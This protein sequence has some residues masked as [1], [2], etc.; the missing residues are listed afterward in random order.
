[1]VELEL[2]GDS[3][4]DMDDSDGD[5]L[6]AM[7]AAVK[8]TTP[9]SKVPEK[10]ETLDTSAAA[11]VIE[12]AAQ[13]ALEA[14]DAAEAAAAEA[15]SEDDLSEEEAH[16]MTRKERLRQ[17]K[18]AKAFFKADAKAAAVRRTG[19]VLEDEAEMSDDGGHTDDE[20][21]VEVEEE[22]ADREG[23]GVHAR[24]IKR[25]VAKRKDGLLDREELEE[26]V[27]Y[28]DF[29][30]TGDDDE[31]RTAKRAAAHAR[32]EE[33]RDDDELRK[34]QEALKNGF[35]RP[36]K[37]K[38]GI[39]GED[40]PDYW[41]RRRKVNGDD[42]DS[43]EEDDVGIDIPDRAWEAVELSDDDDGEWAERAERR[44]NA[45]AA[46][47]QA[48]KK[49]APAHD[50]T[51][52]APHDDWNNGGGAS[53][54]AGTSEGAGAGEDSQL[55]S[56]RD[57][58]FGSGSQ[59]FKAMMHAGRQRRNRVPRS[60]TAAAETGSGP[61]GG[62]GSFGAFAP[63]APQAAATR[64]SGTGGPGAGAEAGTRVGH[65]AQRPG[66]GAMGLE[67]Q[68]ST[69][70]SFMGRS[71]ASR[72]NHGGSSAGGGGGSSLGR[73]I[74]L[75]NGGASRS[76]VFGGGGDSQSMW[77]R[78]AEENGTAAAPTVLAELGGDDNA[79]TDFGWAPREAGG[80]KGQAAGA[81]LGVGAGVGAPMRF[82]GGGGS[83]GQSLFSMLQTSSQDWD[84]ALGR[85][86]SLAEGV[87][88][89]NNIKLPPGVPR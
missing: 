62:V 74:S 55:P 10:E 43:E 9:A 33:E 78:D 30:N 69:S 48:A 80:T 70:F 85:A 5:D 4:A 68:A 41:Q 23:G 50:G 58:G 14:H 52:S 79:R 19:E 1:V 64:P 75:G 54:T 32:F 82:G 11:A 25:K 31:R 29:N 86:D 22:D 89:A 2:E 60:A 71:G 61:A 37:N 72:S 59:D 17:L 47:A 56:A 21:E 26:M 15:P 88:A 65:A 16:E 57:M 7:I 76:F 63:P 44:K 81:G 53:A 84:E 18:R 27:D 87:K 40:G 12:L 24:V 66:P 77:D 36:D 42:E 67:R 46:A 6:A 8:A 3:D 28:I 34:M 49:S 39:M 35:R 13:K 51:A 20:E 83:G 73:S 45:A 38:N